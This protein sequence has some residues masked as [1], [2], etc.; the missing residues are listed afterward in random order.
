MLTQ[1]MAV[2]TDLQRVQK[3][4]GQDIDKL[5]SSQ[6]QPLEVVEGELDR[7][8]ESV[9]DST[10][11][12]DDSHIQEEYA[13]LPQ[14]QEKYSYQLQNQ[15]EYSHLPQSH[16]EHLREKIAQAQRELATL[17]SPEARQLADTDNVGETVFDF[18]PATTRKE[19]KIAVTDPVALKY[20]ISCQRFNESDWSSVQYADVQKRFQASPA[21]TALKVNNLL[22]D[23]TPQWKSI[24]ILERTD[25]TLGAITN[26][27]VQQRIIFQNLLDS[28]PKEVRDRVGREFVFADSEF[29]KNSDSLIQYVC[30]RRAETIQSRRELYKPTNKALKNLLHNIPPSESHLFEEKSFSE[31]VKELGGIHKFFPNKKRTPGPQGPKYRNKTQLAGIKSHRFPVENQN[32]DGRPGNRR[33]FVP[34]ANNTYRPKARNDKSRPTNSTSFQ[35]G[36]K[37]GGRK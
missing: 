34:S 24:Q 37:W 36:K 6:L 4:Q 26:G 18:S 25:L 29:R 33:N 32:R 9:P 5:K 10:C 31:T 27:L 21:F 35:P 2:L 14:C 11:E 17:Q 28:L 15:E 22:T 23:I 3:E 12:E 19:P 30:G 1:Q 20:G 7:S 8:F 16:E 13:H